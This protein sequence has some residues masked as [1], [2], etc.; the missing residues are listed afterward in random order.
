MNNRLNDYLEYLYVTG[1]LNKTMIDDLVKK[2]N[3][4]YGEL[5]EGFFDLSEDE[6]KELLEM[7]LKYQGKIFKK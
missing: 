6:Q 7:S 2:Y 3:D 5:P 1:E 4:I